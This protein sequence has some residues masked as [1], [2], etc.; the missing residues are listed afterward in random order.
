[1]RLGA[2]QRPEVSM[3]A[4][5]RRSLPRLAVGIILSAVVVAQGK[6]PMFGTWKLNVGKSTYSPPPAPKEMT[7]TI[8]AAGAGRRVSVTGV[9]ADGTP[10]KWGYTGNFDREEYKIVGTNPD[11]DVVM[12][13]RLS[14]T[15]T[16]TTFKLKG[17][18]TMVNGLSVSSDGKTLTVE[19]TGIN[20]KGQ[21]IKNHLVL[22]RQ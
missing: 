11:A 1:M 14:A 12:L 22:E 2:I 7:V 20:A 16:R 18:Q 10:V 9:S 6:D 8:E 19:S 15:A 21:P 5:V 17:K 3:N 13:R 4:V